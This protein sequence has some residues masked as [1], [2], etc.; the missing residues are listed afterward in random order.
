MQ[1]TEL[2]PELDMNGQFENCTFQLFKKKREKD[3][4][5]EGIRTWMHVQ[6]KAV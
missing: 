1:S 3:L 5:G 4:S 6:I 2:T